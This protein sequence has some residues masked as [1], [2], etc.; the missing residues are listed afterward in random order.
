MT[1]TSA[2]AFDFLAHYG[3]GHLPGQQLTQTFYGVLYSNPANPNEEEFLAP[4]LFLT[5]AEATEAKARYVSARVV[6]LVAKLVAVEAPATTQE[7]AV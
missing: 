1:Y 7:V 2:N 6:K 4:G 3:V 5:Q